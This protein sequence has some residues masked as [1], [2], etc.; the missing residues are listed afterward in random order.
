VMVAQR[1]AEGGWRSPSLRILVLAASIG[2][3]LI[4]PAARAQI[5]K[6]LARQQW[7]QGTAEY[8]LGHYAQAVAHYEQ[9]YRA[10]PDP[11]FLFN[12]GQAERL[13]GE[14]EQAL[15][16]YRSYL[17]S[18]AEG[19]PKREIAKRWI[20][21]YEGERARDRA[22]SLRP[23]AAAFEAALAG[24]TLSA[25]SSGVPAVSLLEPDLKPPEPRAHRR[26]WLWGAA[27]VVVAAGVTAALLSNGHGGGAVAGSVGTGTVR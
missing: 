21:E 15:L 12:I 1:L 19:A 13:A 25:R 24:P 14:H 10:L 20:A 26:W 2:A 7:E 4:E 27:G 18:S 8:T 16:A 11:V 22:S 9:G 3:E 23:P 5:D 6:D 17:R